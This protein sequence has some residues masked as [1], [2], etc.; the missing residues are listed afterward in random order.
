[1]QGIN[2]SSI[3]PEGKAEAEH[4]VSPDR[5][6]R[7]ALKRKEAFAASVLRELAASHATGVAAHKLGGATFALN[8]QARWGGH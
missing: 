7:A 6:I 1:M 5:L 3:T 4:C 8:V 2:C